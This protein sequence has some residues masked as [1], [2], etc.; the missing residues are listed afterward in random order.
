MV[1]ILRNEKT[2]LIIMP[3]SPFTESE[4]KFITDNYQIL[5]ANE[6]A[7]KFNKERYQIYNFVQGIKLKK[8][9]KREKKI[10]ETGFFNID[11][12]KVW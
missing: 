3:L 12:H 5:E 10:L 4:Q 2:R 1:T 11:L 7:E 6:L 9:K 8:T